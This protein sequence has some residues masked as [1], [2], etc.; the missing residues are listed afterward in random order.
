MVAAQKKLAEPLMGTGSGNR[1]SE[2]VSRDFRKIVFF[3]IFFEQ[4]RCVSFLTSFAAQ[5]ECV[6]SV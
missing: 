3:N 5:S 6:H 4:L 2:P 1:F